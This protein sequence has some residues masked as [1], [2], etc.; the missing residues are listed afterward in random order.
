MEMD[1]PN[2]WG[3]GVGTMATY[4]ETLLD[5]FGYDTGLYIGGDFRVPQFIADQLG[6]VGLIEETFGNVFEIDPVTYDITLDANG[7]GTL[8]PAADVPVP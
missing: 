1:V 3:V 6:T 7:Y 2:T 5:Y 8:I 4:T